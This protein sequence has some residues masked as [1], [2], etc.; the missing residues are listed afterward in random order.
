MAS[1]S[2]YKLAK[3][4]PYDKLLIGLIVCFSILSLLLFTNPRLNEKMAEVYLDG[5]LLEEIDL[6]Q[7][8][9]RELPLTEGSMSLEISKGRIR[10]LESSCPHK[11]CISEG[12]IKNNSRPIVCVP[13][14]V[15]IEIKGIAFQYDAISQ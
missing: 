8:G 14:K 10:V 11:L 2:D 3:V 9:T 13:N 4:S 5:H 15:L 7:D 12:W 6:R 1:S